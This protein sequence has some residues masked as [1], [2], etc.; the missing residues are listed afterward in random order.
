M[1]DIGYLADI[2]IRRISARMIPMF[3]FEYYQQ[4]YLFQV[5]NCFTLF[6]TRCH[7]PLMTMQLAGVL[8]SQTVGCG[9]LRAKTLS[10]PLQVPE[11]DTVSAWS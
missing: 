4:L 5:F 11:E 3:M 2:R 1:P 7:L 9:R 10:R 6:D 8:R